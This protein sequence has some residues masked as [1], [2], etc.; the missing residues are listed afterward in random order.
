MALSRMISEFLLR[1]PKGQ[2]NFLDE[3]I[4]TYEGEKHFTDE[5]QDLESF[6]SAILL[7]FGLVFK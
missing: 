7:E 4:G 1:L 5:E 3:M 6:G 2:V